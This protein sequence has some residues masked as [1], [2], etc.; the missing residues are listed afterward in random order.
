MAALEVYE[1]DHGQD[2]DAKDGGSLLLEQPS[3]LAVPMSDR[4]SENFICDHSYY[5]FLVVCLQKVR[6]RDTTSQGMALKA[7]GSLHYYLLCQLS[8][9]LRASKPAGCGTEPP[10]AA[11]A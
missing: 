10:G 8:S 4:Q 11:S 2:S 9:P 5:I 3:N 6:L 7:F 1:Q